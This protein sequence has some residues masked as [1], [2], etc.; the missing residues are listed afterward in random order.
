MNEHTARHHDVVGKK[1]V[2]TLTKN[3]FQA[4]YCATKAEAA[5]AVLRLVPEAVTVGVGGSWTIVE[6]GILETLKERGCTIL[7]HNAPGLDAAEKFRIRRAQ[8]TCDVFLTGSNAVTMDGRLVNV[9]GTGNRVAA[10]IF[11]PGKVI[12]VAGINKVARDLGAAEERIRSV[13]APVN[14]SRIGLP[15]PCVK[16]GECMDCQGPTRICNV[17]T[18]IGKRPNATEMHVIIVGED[19]GF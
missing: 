3:G 8:L 13:A 16:T 4:L 15:N 17:T 2:E 7:N 12:V 1:V 6:L 19:M 11:G 14:N 10:M 5:E 18:I 9:D